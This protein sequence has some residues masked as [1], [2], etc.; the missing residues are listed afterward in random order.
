MTVKSSDFLQPAY[1]ELTSKD[2]IYYKFL[3]VILHKFE[4]YLFTKISLAFVVSVYKTEQL[5]F[6]M[7]SFIS[8]FLV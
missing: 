5:R 7:H 3:S 6:K 8:G 1:Q 2:I 4:Y